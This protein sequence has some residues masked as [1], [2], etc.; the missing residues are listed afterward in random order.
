VKHLIHVTDANMHLFWHQLALAIATPNK[1]KWS[2]NLLV[3]LL[4]NKS[5]LILAEGSF[6]TN[7]GMMCGSESH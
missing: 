4:I 1:S 3:L 2:A 5:F 7:E 6:L